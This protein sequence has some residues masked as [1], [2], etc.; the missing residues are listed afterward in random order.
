LRSQVRHLHIR[1]RQTGGL[2]DRYAEHVDHLWSS[3]QA[4]RLNQSRSAIARLVRVSDPNMSI[5]FDQPCLT[6]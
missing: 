5:G 3:A 2:L 6:I 1:R 4:E